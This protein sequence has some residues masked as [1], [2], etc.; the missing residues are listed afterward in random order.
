MKDLKINASQS[1]GNWWCLVAWLILS[2][3]SGCTAPP[4]PTLNLY[5]AIQAGDLDQIKRHLHWG[6]D[7]NQAGPD[8]DY[9]LHMAARRGQVVVVEE[10]VRHGAVRDV[11]DAHGLTP[12]ELALLAGKTQV[13]RILLQAGAR[14][15]PQ[16]LLQVLVDQG[17]SDRDTLG[18]VVAQGADVNAPDAQG[19][20]PLHRA[21]RA[22]QVLVVKRLIALGADVNLTDGQGLSPLALAKAG[23]QADI[24]ALL[25]AFGA[26]LRPP[27]FKPDH[28][29]KHP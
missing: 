20:P 17:V 3:L 8:G 21:I 25:N 16:A 1:C 19:V 6:T 2:T 22:S 12:L 5:R 18:L 13:A 24:A 23:N 27:P 26:S 11:R 14:Q 7:I 10:L 28:D 4:E 15:D 29:A 9:P